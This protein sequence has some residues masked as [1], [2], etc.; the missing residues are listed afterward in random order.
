M[1]AGWA[2][3]TPTAAGELAGYAA[4]AGALSQGTHDELEAALLV[5]DDGTTTVAWLSLDVL[6]VAEP[7]AEDLR[8]AVAA[9]LPCD[10]VLVCASHTHSGPLAWPELLSAVTGFVTR[11]ASGPALQVAAEWVDVE[12]DGVGTN[13]LEPSGPHDRTLGMLQLRDAEGGIRAVMTDFATHPTVLGPENLLW[14]ADWP[15]AFRSQLRAALGGP[16]VLFTQGAAGDVSTRFTRRAATF[17]EADRLGK[18]AATAAVNPGPGRTL[19]PRLGLAGAAVQVQRRPL[20]A[21]ADAELEVERAAAEVAALG[22]DALNPG[23]RLAQTRLDGARVQR[24]LVLAGGSGPIS[25]PISAATLGDVAWVYLPV[26]PFASVAEA[27]TD[28]SPFATTR[29]IG[30]TNGYAGY[31]A[32]EAAHRDGTYEALSSV[33]AP[34]AADEVADAAV[35]LL[36]ARADALDVRT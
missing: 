7:L 15:G 18:I 31:L 29:V 13:R 6:G 26:E 11:V 1:R 16:V 9:A 28:R 35:A 33:F 4:R 36:A 27:I 23:V 3:I 5:L 19:T 10:E 22:D 17:D 21:L 12:V 14:S 30:Y 20:P 34:Q 24:D 25:L 8:A 32:D 2:V